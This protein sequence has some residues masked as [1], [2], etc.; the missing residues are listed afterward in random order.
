M[1]IG[2]QYVGCSISEVV[3][4]KIHYFIVPRMYK[5]Y[6][7]EG[8]T[9]SKGQCSGHSYSLNDRDQQ[10]LSRNDHANWLAHSLRGS[11]EVCLWR[12]FSEIR[13]WWDMASE[14]WLLNTCTRSISSGSASYLCLQ[15]RV[16]I[17]YDWK[18]VLWS[19][20]LYF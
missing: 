2:A 14:D 1:L 10:F 17:L 19:S 6:L 4:F 5:Q 12:P 11:L 9:S 7:V 8:I 16:L 20:M 15:L 18:K 3:T 13:Y